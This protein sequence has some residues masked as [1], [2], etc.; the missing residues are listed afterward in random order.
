MRHIVV[1]A[2]VAGITIGLGAAERGQTRPAG[3]TPASFTTA[4]GRLAARL[5]RRAARVA[6]SAI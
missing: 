6:T 3:L 4:Q 1:L 2:V 5:T